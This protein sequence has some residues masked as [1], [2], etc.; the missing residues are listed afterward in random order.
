MSYIK[1][2]SCSGGDFE[3]TMSFKTTNGTGTG[4]INLFMRTRDGI[5]VGDS[6]LIE[7][8]P[9]G[10]YHVR[11]DGTAAPNPDCDPTQ[12]PCEMWLPGNYS[13]EVGKGIYPLLGVK[14]SKWYCINF[15]LA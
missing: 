9:P 6:E 12:G 8:Q 1:L 5:P 3:I 7:P 14:Q 4:E 13:V 10:T 11:W 2:C 15:K